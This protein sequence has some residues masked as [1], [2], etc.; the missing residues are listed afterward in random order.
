[1][2]AVEQEQRLFGTSNTTLDDAIRSAIGVDHPVEQ[3][4]LGR[5]E[6]VA[7]RGVVRGRTISFWQVVLKPRLGAV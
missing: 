2:N 6:V 4:V 3:D 5:Y 7:V 1:M